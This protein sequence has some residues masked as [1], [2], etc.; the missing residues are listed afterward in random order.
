MIS[1]KIDVIYY[2]KPHGK[3]K[4]FSH[5]YSERWSLTEYFCPQCGK[6][7]VWIRGD[8][9]D[10]ELG[11][12]HI[13]TECEHTFYLPDGVSKASDEQDVQRLHY[14]KP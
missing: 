1:K 8:G 2:I 4:E 14:L 13:C 7:D 3:S 12:K 6:K 5:K 11:E 10:C 9:G